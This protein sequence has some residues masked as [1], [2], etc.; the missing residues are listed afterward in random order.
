MNY[1]AEKNER[2]SRQ[3]AVVLAIGLHLGLAAVLYLGMSEKPSNTAT[4]HSVA[5][6]EQHPQVN[7]KPRQVNMP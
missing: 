2:K 4:Q 1:L 6:T 5:Q 3:Q 7:A